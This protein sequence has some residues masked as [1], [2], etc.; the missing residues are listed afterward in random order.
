[1]TTKSSSKFGVQGSSLDQSSVMEQ[2]LNGEDVANILQVSKSFAYQLIRCGDI[3]S[4]RLGRAV[5]VR[6]QDLE[7]FIA[8]NVCGSHGTQF[9]GGIDR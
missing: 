6:L 1:M 8:S 7:R 5:R 9:I 2:L 3:P 4:V